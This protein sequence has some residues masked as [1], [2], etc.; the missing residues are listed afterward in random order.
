[1]HLDHGI[2]RYLGRTVIAGSRGPQDVLTLEYADGDRL[3]V[4]M[5]QLH[6]VQRYVAFGSRAPALHKLGGM[7][8]GRAKVQAF[9]GAW[10]YAKGLLDVQ[11]KR[12]ALPGFAYSAD[13]PWQR[14][15]EAA[16]PFRET[17]DQAVATAEV[18]RNME[19]PRPMDRL[20]MGDVGYGKTEVAMR[21]AFKAVMDHKQV[22]VLVPTTILAFQHHR[23]F[24][25]RLQPFPVQIEMLTRF[26]SEAE[27]RRVMDAVAHGRVDV[28]IGT[29]RLLSGDVQFKDLGLVVV[30]EEQRFGVQDKERLKRWR[31]QTDVLTL[32][33]TPIPR[34]LYLSLVGARE[35]SV[36]AIP[37]ENRHPVETQVVEEDDKALAQWV[38]R[39]LERGGQ[40]YLV[41][42]RVRSIFK[43]AQRLSRLVPEARVG[44]A[45]GRM[46]EAE[47]EQVMMAFI[48]GRMDVLVTTTIIESGIDI[49]NANTL[50]VRQAEAFGLADLYQLRGRV[51]RFDRKAY[52]YLVVS[53]GGVLS[54]EARR[55]LEAMCE[56]A[57]LGSG[58]RIAMEDLKIRGAG[59][60]LGLE[61]SGHISAVGF[62]L[63]CR[64]LREA[65]ARMRGRETG[66]RAQQQVEG[67]GSKVEGICPSTFHL[68]PSTLSATIHHPRSRT[69]F[70]WTVGIALSC[71]LMVD[72]VWAETVNRM[73]AIVEEDVIT[74]ADVAAQMHTLLADAREEP[75]DEATAG[76]M[77]QAIL[78]RLIEQRL[79]LQEAKRSGIIVESEEVLDRLEDI[80]GQFDSEDAFRN[81]LEE[82]GMSE[83]QLKGQIREALIVQR[84]V[85]ERVRSTITV[86]PQDVAEERTAHPEPPHSGEQAR[87]R[88]LLIRAREGRSEEEA[89]RLADEAHRRLR[90]GASFAEL[91]KRDS[92]DAHKDDGG[93]MGWVAQEELLP[94]LQAAVQALKVGEPSAPIRTKLGFHLVVVEERRAGATLAE[95]DVVQ[96]I[97][98]RLY[99]RKFQEAM[100]RRLDELTR[101]AYIHILEQ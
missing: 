18:K 69:L 1:V 78:R 31:T 95:A 37:P 43:V 15:F 82:S 79:L 67:R 54:A 90:E 73:M 89:K 35:L 62:D 83:E 59:N 70:T 3:Y 10:T 84:W 74:E 21:A 41:H 63:Y 40:V 87:L 19:D 33:A 13:H 49:P 12:M 81:G 38:L 101:K 96:Y 68:P 94:E 72:P 51:G 61:Q 29:H 76:A 28:V 47:L 7:A 14:E 56:H 91:A 22:A 93:A 39:E 17:R 80:R 23:T 100:T 11:A 6:L 92:E 44:V 99:Q 58:F 26:Q 24:A 8:W 60:L 46:G 98:Q 97:R 77:R 65:V 86:S 71:C 42:N 27:Q 16:F 45:H 32:S 55:R 66:D 48:E 36:L 20:L 2:G 5:D 75:A 88:H 50:I 4:P 34:T 9:V 53:K 64:L 52:A 85:D 30:D 25:A 57:A